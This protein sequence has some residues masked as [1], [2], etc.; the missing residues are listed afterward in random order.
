MSA[1]ELRLVVPYLRDPMLSNWDTA[2]ARALADWLERTANDFADLVKD[3]APEC[4][5]CGEGCAGHPSANFCD[6]CSE[7]VESP[8][9]APCRCW[10]EALTTARALAVS[11]GLASW[12]DHCLH[13]MEGD[14]PCCRCGEPNWCPDDGETSE[15][16]ELF[17]LRRRC[18][19]PEVAT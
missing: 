15:A 3:D 7:A 4:P 5:N 19:K 6:R 10:T 9:Y 18:A 11:L 14:G 8:H 2:V 16:L 17:E 13:W 12:R 1:T